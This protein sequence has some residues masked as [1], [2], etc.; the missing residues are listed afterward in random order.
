MHSQAQHMASAHQN[1]GGKYQ[2][3]KGDKDQRKKQYKSFLSDL[4][5]HINKKCKPSKESDTKEHSFNMESF[6]YEQFCELQVS[7]SSDLDESSAKCT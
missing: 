4:A 7:D 2:R 3:K 5:Q 6:N 1:M